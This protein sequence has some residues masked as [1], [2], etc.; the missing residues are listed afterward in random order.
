MASRVVALRKDLSIERGENVL[1]HEHRFF[2]S[3]TNDPMLSADE[4]VG[5]AALI[6]AETSPVP[7]RQGPLTASPETGEAASKRSR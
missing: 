2:F 5:Q 1:I 4:I 7:E 3:V 6:L